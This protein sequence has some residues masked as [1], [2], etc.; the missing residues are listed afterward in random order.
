MI[1][2]NVSF[3]FLLSLTLVIQSESFGLKNIVDVFEYEPSGLKVGDTYYIVTIGLLGHINIHSS[4]DF[5]SWHP[6]DQNQDEDLS[7]WRSEGDGSRI[8]SPE[9]HQFKGRFNLYY[10]TLKEND[11]ACKGIGVASG[12]APIGPFEDIGRPLLSL[13]PEWVLNPHVA[14]DGMNLHYFNVNIFLSLSCKGHSVHCVLHR[15]SAKKNLLF[16]SDFYVNNRI[17]VKKSIF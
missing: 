11:P 3:L 8:Y 17:N 2:L 10:D 5:I 9:I 6:E 1:A 14:H 13:C 16:R 7:G 4:K 12:N 15:R